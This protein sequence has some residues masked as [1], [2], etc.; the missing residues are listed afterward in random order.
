MSAAPSPVCGRASTEFSI[1]T[2]SAGRS[3]S[4]SAGTPVSG[5]TGADGGESAETTESRKG[6]VDRCC[7]SVGQATTPAATSTTS[8]AARRP[9]LGFA[10]RRPF[11]GVR[12]GERALFVLRA[13]FVVRAP[14]V[15][16]ERGRA[17]V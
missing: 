11:G 12:F 5:Q 6:T 17:A 3:V 4:A 2:A 7:R 9:R 15:G 16:P 10:R 1:F 13:P 14:L 8:T